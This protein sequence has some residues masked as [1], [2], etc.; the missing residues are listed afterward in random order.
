LNVAVVAPHVAHAR[1][2]VDTGD[3]D[4]GDHVVVMPATLAATSGS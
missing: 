3:H 1:K 4:T 2:G